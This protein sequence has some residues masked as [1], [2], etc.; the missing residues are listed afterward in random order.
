MVTDDQQR[1]WAR[2]L[3]ELSASYRDIE[4]MLTI[5]AYKRGTRPAAD[6]A[7]ERHEPIVTFL[8]QRK[9]ETSSWETTLLAMKNAV[10]G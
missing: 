6:R 3:R 4:D 10:T 2:D 1:E 5:G 7:I 8:K 9:E